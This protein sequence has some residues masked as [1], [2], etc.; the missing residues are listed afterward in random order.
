MAFDCLN[1]PTN[2]HCAFLNQFFDSNRRL[3]L[4]QSF[5]RSQEPTVSPTDPTLLSSQKNA[6]N[7]VKALMKAFED[8][9]GNPDPQFAFDALTK[10]MLVD[11][12]ASIQIAEGYAKDLVE[13]FTSSLR[14]QLNLVGRALDAEILA[15]KAGNKI[16]D[17]NTAGKKKTALKKYADSL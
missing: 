14:Q 3:S 15:L 2:P 8:T 7:A 9:E 4:P 13:A 16:G 12:E 1:F 17:A 6:I 11:T 10:L 5:V